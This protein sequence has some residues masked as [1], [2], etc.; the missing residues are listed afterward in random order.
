MYTYF[1][2]LWMLG[3]DHN[4]G[5]F[6]SINIIDMLCHGATRLTITRMVLLTKDPFC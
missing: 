6:L 3:R 5:F 4:E 2:S 1:V